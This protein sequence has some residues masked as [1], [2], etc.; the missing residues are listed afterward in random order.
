MN[1]FHELYRLIVRMKH[2]DAKSAHKEIFIELC[3]L[4]EQ[5]DFLVILMIKVVLRKENIY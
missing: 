5:F 2:I 3:E 4:N 1:Q